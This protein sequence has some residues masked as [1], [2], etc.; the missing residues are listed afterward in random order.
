MIETLYPVQ[1]KLNWL[2]RKEKRHFL[3]ARIRFPL[4]NHPLNFFPSRYAE[5]RPVW[6]REQRYNTEGNED[7]GE[8][9][10]VVCLEG[11][12]ARVGFQY[13]SRHRNPSISMLDK[14]K[15]SVVGLRWERWLERDGGRG[16]VGRLSSRN[17][18]ARTMPVGGATRRHKDTDMPTTFP[19]SITSIRPLSLPLSLSLSLSINV[20]PVFDF[21]SFILGRR[22]Q[23]GKWPRNSR[24]I[25]VR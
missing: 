10:L 17:T 22:E 4:C 21:L 19:T 11:R 8:R 3:H 24:S 16:G 1:T 6:R 7:E 2:I 13:K 25:Y 14:Q 15:Q 20:L 9:G 23:D 12:T 18:R 5:H